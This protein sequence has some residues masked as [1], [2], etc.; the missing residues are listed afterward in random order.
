MFT[1]PSA[2]QQ[3]SGA[4]GLI[5]WVSEGSSV[6]GIRRTSAPGVVARSGPVYACTFSRDFTDGRGEA[7]QGD[8]HIPDTAG[9]D[10]VDG[11]YYIRQCHDDAGV[12]VDFGGFF[13]NAGGDNGMITG[14]SDAQI[15]DFLRV[16]TSSQ[17]RVIPIQLNPEAQQVTGIETWISFDPAEFVIP[18]DFATTGSISAGIRGRL[19]RVAIQ[20]GDGQTVN[21]NSFTPW[22]PGATN[23]QC[24]YTYFEEPPSGQYTMTVTYFW[25]YE[26]L[27]HDAAG[28]WEPLE[29]DVAITGT[30]TVPVID[31]EAV[32]SR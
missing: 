29:D 15:L 17:P 28:G 3:D 21:C 32:I 7:R 16:Q 6:A 23:P 1:S 2:A 27:P 24:S 22:T 4:D 20:T 26:W 14:A 8:R 31:L 30:F 25:D 19:D 9:P 18:E 13:Y 10:L 11:L 5:V 12:E